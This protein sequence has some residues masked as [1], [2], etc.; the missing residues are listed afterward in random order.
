[1][2]ATPTVKLDVPMK[3]PPAVDS[4]GN[5]ADDEG[6]GADSED[7]MAAARQPT[8]PTTSSACSLALSGA[9]RS[10]PTGLR[11]AGRGCWRPA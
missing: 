6:L 8:A 3:E 11:R 10:P 7:Q 4:T 9:A 5:M 1:M 2:F